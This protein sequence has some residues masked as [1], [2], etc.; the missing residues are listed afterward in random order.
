VEDNKVEL[1]VRNV[2]LKGILKFGSVY[3]LA[4][5]IEMEKHF[6][7]G[8][9]VDVINEYIYD[10][11]EQEDTPLLTAIGLHKGMMVQWLLA[12]GADTT[13]KNI[14]MYSGFDAL[15]CARRCNYAEAERWIEKSR[16]GGERAGGVVTHRGG[17]SGAKRSRSETDVDT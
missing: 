14:E 6:Y 11:T 9:G 10:T 4:Y 12:N 8:E 5:F 16:R 1:Y 13:E 2:F 3:Q 17:I 7:E 15:A